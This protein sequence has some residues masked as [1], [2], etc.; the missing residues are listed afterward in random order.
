MKRFVEGCVIGVFAVYCLFTAVS[1]IL[2]VTEWARPSS[3]KLLLPPCDFRL[4]LNELACLRDGVNPYSVWHED[5][6]KVPYYPLHKPEMAN[7]VLTEPINA[8]TPWEYTMAMPFAWLPR[9]VAWGSYVILMFVCLAVLLWGGYDVARRA[10]YVGFSVWSFAAIPLL[11]VAH[12]IWSN[13]CIE[14]MPCP[15]WLLFS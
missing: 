2:P 4:R 15:Y 6:A 8:Y 3:D 10:G 9:R 1:S 14:I 7:A 5:V 12:P 13:F 11:V